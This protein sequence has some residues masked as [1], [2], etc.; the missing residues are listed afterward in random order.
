MFNLFKRS[1]ANGTSAAVRLDSGTTPRSDAKFHDDFWPLPLPEVTEGA[2]EADWQLWE[3]SVNLVESQF[4]AF[5]FS[6]R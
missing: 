4:G 1:L 2:S 6:R 5:D 3:E